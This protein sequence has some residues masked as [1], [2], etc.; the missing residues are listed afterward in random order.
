M[1]ICIYIYIDIYIYV[2]VQTSYVAAN[3]VMF[4]NPD[5][6]LIIH[7]YTDTFMNLCVEA[8]EWATSTH[9]RIRIADIGIHMSSY[10]HIYPHACT[11]IR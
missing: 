8:L 6:M 11:F 7:M 1:Y 9:I 4:H 3:R 5:V 10:V 2:C